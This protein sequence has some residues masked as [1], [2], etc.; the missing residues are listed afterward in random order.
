MCNH[1]GKIGHIMGKCY[2]LIG[3]PPSYK[4]KGKLAM[5]NQVI[6]E[7]DQCQSKIAHQKNPF[8]FTSE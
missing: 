6:V 2:K 1:C 4:Q 8:P 7:G 3:Y 5:A